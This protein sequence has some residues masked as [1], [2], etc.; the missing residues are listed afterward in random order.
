VADLSTGHGPTPGLSS[1]REALVVEAT[2][3]IPSRLRRA[4][5][6]LIF[7]AKYAAFAAALGRRQNSPGAGEIK[8]TFTRQA[9]K[10][11]R[12]AGQQ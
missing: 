3:P 11:Q 10:H 2:P 8:A 6:V 9:G 12:A 7:E 4:C 5:V 1:R